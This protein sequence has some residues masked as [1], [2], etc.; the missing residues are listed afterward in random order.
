LPINQAFRETE[1]GLHR[2]TQDTHRKGQGQVADDPVLGQGAVLILILEQP[3]VGG[4][5]NTIQVSA[6]Q[7]RDGSRTYGG[8]VP[9][10]GVHL[11]C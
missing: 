6:F 11:M 7:C 3:R 2:V 5:E 8:V 10:L 4:G 9:T 1:D